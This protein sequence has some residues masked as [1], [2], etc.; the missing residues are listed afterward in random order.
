[1]TGKVEDTQVAQL[2]QF[3]APVQVIYRRLRVHPAVPSTPRIHQDAC[4]QLALRIQIK[5]KV[6][7]FLGEK[8]IDLM[9]LALRH[10]YWL[11]IDQWRLYILLRQHQDS[12]R[13]WEDGVPIGKRPGL[14]ISI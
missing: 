6:T 2:G 8:G 1:M 11:P 10:S 7:G 14:L 13:V 12:L 5:V 4:Q 9:E 3:N